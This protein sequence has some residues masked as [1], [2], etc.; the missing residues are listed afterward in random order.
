MAFLKK[1][2]WD[3]RKIFVDFDFGEDNLMRFLIN[4]RREKGFFSDLFKLIQLN[5]R[6]S[7]SGVL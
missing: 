5:H 4:Y 1:K 3:M 7:I 6:Y 2:L